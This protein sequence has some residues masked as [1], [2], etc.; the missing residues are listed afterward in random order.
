MGS[1]DAGEDVAC[2]WI[3]VGVEESGRK[4]FEVRMLLGTERS[5]ANYEEK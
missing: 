4:L 1:V 3:K 5:L 2:S